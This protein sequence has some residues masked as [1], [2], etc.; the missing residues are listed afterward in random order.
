MTDLPNSFSMSHIRAGFG[1]AVVITAIVI[2]IPLQWI[3]MKLRLPTARYIPVLFHRISLKALGVRIHL[4]GTC[5]QQGAVLI[6]ANHSS[7]LDIPVLGSLQPLSFIAKSEVSGWPVFGL[8]AKLQRTVFVNRTRRSETGAV[9]AEIAQR[10]KSG[11]AMVLFPEG[12]S[13]DGN[14]VLP[15]RSA[16]IGAAKAAMTAGRD[17]KNAGEQRPVWI[18]PLSV[19]YNGIQGL[20][21]GRQHRH[22]VAWY[23]DMDL[24]PHLWAVMKEGAI[25]VTVTFGEPIFFDGSTN[26]K[27]VA[28]KAEQSVRDMMLSDLHHKSVSGL[29]QPD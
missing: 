2:G 16:L 21:M 5:Q 17:E 1:L 7:W 24:I 11:D 3:S 9:T 25:D 12:T 18:Q 20:A 19:A 6:T 26:R 14:Q 28:L 13:S 27:S 8:L 29:M 23:G 4:K 15:F 22:M 10:L